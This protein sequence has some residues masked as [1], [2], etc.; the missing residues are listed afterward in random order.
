MLFSEG[1]RDWSQCMLDYLQE[2]PSTYVLVMLD[3]FFLRKPVS[4][5]NVL[6]CLEFAQR[7]DAT[8][9]R[10][11]PRPGPTKKMLG[12][13]LIGECTAGQ[14]YRL[15]TQAAIWNRSKLIELLRRGE[16]IWEFE[17]NGNQRI[18]AINHGFFAV[19][20]PVLPYEGLLA[21]HVVEKGRWIPHEKWIFGRQNIGCDFSR[22]A[23]LSMGQTILYHAASLID[24]LL[25]V[26]PWRT[27][28]AVKGYIKKIIRPIFK[29]QL[30][31][32]SGVK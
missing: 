31:S 19:S 9:V 29:R 7:H 32:M 6:A 18:S 2:L 1:G 3:D 27:K 24:R 8:Q 17:H 28:M 11:V 16:S 10:L 25:D 22:R 4:T 5:T 23:T 15:S 21:H 20:S 12:N 26:L 14:P 13:H 30:S